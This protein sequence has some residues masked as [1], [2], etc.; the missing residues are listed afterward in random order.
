MTFWR[1]AF[2]KYR[3]IHDVLAL[4]A[5]DLANETGELMYGNPTIV[6]NSASWRS[7][8][9]LVNEQTWSSLRYTLNVCLTKSSRSEKESLLGVL[10]P[11]SI[12]M[13]CWS[14]MHGTKRW[15]SPT[16]QHHGRCYGFYSRP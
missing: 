1:S 7:T 14:S 6:L 5:E 15:A 9:K 11:A 16:L 3:R 10:S 13:I 2:R 12:K 8:L 4:A